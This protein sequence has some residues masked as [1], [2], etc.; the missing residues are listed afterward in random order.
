MLQREQRGGDNWR[1]HDVHVLRAAEPKKES[2]T[3]DWRNVYEEGLHIQHCP[4]NGINVW[5]KRSEMANYVAE[6]CI[7]N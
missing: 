2:E 3:R 7:Q 4:L 5:S 6:K 1:E